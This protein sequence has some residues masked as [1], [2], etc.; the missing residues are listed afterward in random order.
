MEI[1]ISRT[2]PGV[3]A[4]P[5]H[6]HDWWEIMS[7][8]EGVGYL[9]TPERNYPFTPGTVILVPPHVIHGS[10]SETDL[11]ISQSAAILKISSSP[12][13]PLCYPTTAVPNA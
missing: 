1:H 7:Y 6:A 3:R 4:Y 11:Q 2:E 12:M 5:A 10:V 13:L 9:Y 8:S